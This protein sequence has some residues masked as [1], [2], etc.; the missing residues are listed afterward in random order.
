MYGLFSGIGIGWILY[1]IMSRWKSVMSSVPSGSIWGPVLFN[2][3]ISN[4]G[5]VIKCT[6]SIFADE[7]RTDGVVHTP[8]G[9]DDIQRE[10]DKLE[11]HDA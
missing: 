8:E 10:L 2:I 1:S 4:T 6:L 11:C 5:S 3:F 9:Q 7:T